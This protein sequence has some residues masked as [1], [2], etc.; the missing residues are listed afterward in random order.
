MSHAGLAHR[1]NDLGARQGHTLRYDKSSVTRWIG[2]R[3][4]RGM[5]PYLIAEALSAKV[6]QP[7]S[8]AD[9]SFTVPNC[10]PS[11]HTP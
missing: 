10:P 6:G 1:V 3:H 7:L 11:R 9:C 5:A 2:G 8:P 4:P